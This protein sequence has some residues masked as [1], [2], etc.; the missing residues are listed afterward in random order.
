MA[1]PREPLQA[2]DIVIKTLF[3][4]MRVENENERERERER[5]GEKRE[6][7]GEI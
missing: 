6:R 4:G 3:A 2:L 7:E 1:T 5:E